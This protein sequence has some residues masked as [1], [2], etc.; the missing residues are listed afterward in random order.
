MMFRRCIPAAEVHDVTTRGATRPIVLP[1]QNRKGEG[2]N[3]AL[4]TASEFPLHRTPLQ[5]LSASEQLQ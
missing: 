3:S 4:L 1:K 2:I 5:H